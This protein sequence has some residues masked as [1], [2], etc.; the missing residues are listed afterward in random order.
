[1]ADRL[2]AV[3]DEFEV[4]T[5]HQ[6]LEYLHSASLGRM[7]LKVGENI[8]IFPVN[9]ASDGAIVVFRTASGTRLELATKGRVAFEVDGWDPEAGVGWSV[10]LKGVASDV[11]SGHDPFSEALRERKV[12]PLAPGPR[13]RWIAIYPSEISGR[14]LRHR[15]DGS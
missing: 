13:E 7:G 1:M 15:A 4:L 2:L 6:C 11:T 8:E 9:Y 14:R 12:L 5:E 3:I 10:L